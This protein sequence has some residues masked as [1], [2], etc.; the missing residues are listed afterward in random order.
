MNI[1]QRTIFKCLSF[2]LLLG[3]FCWATP[4]SAEIKLSFGVYTADK[5]TV[6]VKTF[7]PL[8]KLLE[9]S[10]A[11]TLGE[12]VKI[13]LQVAST[14]AG[15]IDDISTGK[16]DFSRL[17][18]ASYIKAKSLQ[19]DIHI[20]ALEAKNGQKLFRGVIAVAENSSIKDVADL[21][22]KRFAFGDKRSTIGRYLVQLYL[23]EKQLQ[24]ADLAYYEY[25][26]R[27]DKVGA[28]VASGQFDAGALK[29]STY[30]RLVDNGAALRVLA[31]FHNVT[32]PWIARAGL[33]ERIVSALK[34]SL[35]EISDPMALEALQK[36]GFVDGN[37]TD[38]AIIR[39]AI[40][41]NPR[42]FNQSY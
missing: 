33:D 19:P 36:D 24:A 18:P 5:P 31:T 9:R 16:V 28:A 20:L 13:K 4:A 11:K 27:H 3:P 41:Q 7:K 32:K 21:K 26:G 35:L 12:P 15:G 2:A 38:Y 29:Q 23:F 1:S 14:Y 30:K 6:V 37:D 8:L 17:G 40:D 34:A 42:F 39:R 25:L 10:V 22:G